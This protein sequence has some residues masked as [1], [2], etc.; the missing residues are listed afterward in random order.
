MTVTLHYSIFYCFS[1]LFK[2]D[3][4]TRT[5]AATA[6]SKLLITGTPDQVLFVVEQ[7]AIAPLCRLLSVE[8]STVIVAILDAL[9]HILR[10]AGST[11]L[12]T[13]RGQIEECGGLTKLQALQH[14]HRD[15]VSHK[16]HHIM[17]TYFAS[18]NEDYETT[19]KNE[20]QE[21]TPSVYDIDTDIPLKRHEDEDDET[22]AESTT[23]NGLAIN[24]NATTG[25]GMLV[26]IIHLRYIR[27]VGY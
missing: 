14:D 18:S 8:D 22:V 27:Y 17:V 1:Y 6:I 9:M 12:D 5:D 7:R 25:G 16:A 11:A 23:P 2:S 4:S 20:L 3:L 26:K 13:V 21:S 15:A 19:Q 24:G 10:K